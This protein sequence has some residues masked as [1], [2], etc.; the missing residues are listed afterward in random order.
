ME[1]PTYKN[2][3]FQ[4]VHVDRASFLKVFVYFHTRNSKNDIPYFWLKCIVAGNCQMKR[5]KLANG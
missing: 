1:I 4:H 2:R 3:E 5:N